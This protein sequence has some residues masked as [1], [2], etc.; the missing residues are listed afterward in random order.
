MMFFPTFAQFLGTSGWRL[1]HAH[2]RAEHV[3]FI[4]FEAILI[5]IFT[6]FY[7][8]VTFNPIDQADNLKKYGGFIPG[9]RPGRP[10]AEY[11]DRI[12]TRLTFPG[13]LFLAALAV[14]PWLIRYAAPQRPVL[15]RRHFAAHRGRRRARHD[16]ADGGAAPHAA[17]RGL[18]EVGDCHD[19]ANVILLGGP[20]AG[21][22]TQAERIVADYGVPHISTGEMLRAAVAKGT[23]WVARRRSTWTP[24]RSSPTRSSIGARARAAHR[25]GR[26]RGLPPRRLPAHGA[27][28]EA[29]DEHRLAHRV[30][31]DESCSASPAALDAVAARSTTSRSTRPRP[32]ASATRRRRTHARADDN[33]ETVRNRIAIYE[34]QRRRSSGTESKARRS[35]AKRRRCTG[36][37]TILAANAVVAGKD[38]DSA[39]ARRGRT[40]PLRG[41]GRGGVADRASPSRD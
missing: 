29:L 23:R 36:R 14:L 27:Q 2:V 30:P 31:A 38:G 10:T 19:S 37:S 3:P 22:G 41:D 34:Q 5:V 21:K 4:I 28:A 9:V 13:A 17:L 20:G 32:T 1:G 40:S 8:A 25:A 35:A 24:A 11:L 39:W 33:E 26:R 6:Y 12:L 7:T 16:A 18:P 15:L